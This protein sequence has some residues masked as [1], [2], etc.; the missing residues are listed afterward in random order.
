[1]LKASSIAVQHLRLNFHL[2][3]KFYFTK[4]SHAY[5]VLEM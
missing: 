2:R 1:M 3:N 5:N 4:D